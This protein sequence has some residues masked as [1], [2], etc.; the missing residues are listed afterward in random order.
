LGVRYVLEGSVRRHGDRIR[1]SA[2][3]IEAPSGTHRWAE[4]YDRKL[5]DVFS[6]QDEVVRTIATILAA[7]VKKA[8]IERTR[9][10][11]PNSWKAY[12]FYLQAADA[13]ASFNDATDA[14]AICEA[15]G[16]PNMRFVET[17][18]AMIEGL[19]PGCNAV[20]LPSASDPRGQADQEITGDS[21]MFDN[22]S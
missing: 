22:R 10:K 11:P 4:H 19:R 7:H 21:H 1:V 20:F 2:Q 15:V 8:E 18:R 5:E 12:D 6:F 13:F 17:K 9:T 3:L 14:E 16:R